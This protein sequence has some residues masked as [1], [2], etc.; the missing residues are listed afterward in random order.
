MKSAYDINKIQEL[1][2]NEN[3]EWVK[4]HENC[5]KTSC[6]MSESDFQLVV[7][8]IADSGKKVKIDRHIYPCRIIG[9]YKYWTDEMIKYAY[10][11][12]RCILLPES[13]ELEGLEIPDYDIAPGY[14]SHL[15][16][17]FGNYW[18][19]REVFEFSCGWGE[20]LRA[21]FLDLKRY[22]G[23]DSNPHNITLFK[24]QYPYAHGRIYAMSFEEATELWISGNQFILGTFGAASH[25]KENSL[26]LLEES[27]KDYFIMFNNE[28]DY[29]NIKVP[30]TCNHYTIKE[31]KAL[32]PSSHIL[33]FNSYYV[34]SNIDLHTHEVKR[35][36]DW[37]LSHLDILFR[38]SGSN[39]D[40]PYDTLFPLQMESIM[41]NGSKLLNSYS[42]YIDYSN[43]K[44]DFASIATRYEE[45][46]AKYES[47]IPF[48]EE[49]HK[50]CFEIIM[51][52][53]SER[54]EFFRKLQITPN[55]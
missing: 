2:E 49:W 21:L 3:W 36:T 48:I 27:G 34:V 50:E 43:V 30:D 7:N 35:I 37:E 41:K 33:P 32:M 55:C 14:V 12:N 40:I 10:N 23:I 28:E 9:N 45:Y 51:T 47:I 6:K 8:A 15:E 17:V 44:L 25:L 46:I 29:P 26:N 18:Q 20:S 42:C 11:L 13:E 52:I 31:I 19:N 22:I 1:L 24:K 38:H 53:V 4:T 39:K 16:F 54:L 5:F